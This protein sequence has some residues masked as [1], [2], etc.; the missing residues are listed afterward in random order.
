MKKAV[1]LV[2]FLVLSWLCFVFWPKSN[3]VSEKNN[4]SENEGVRNEVESNNGPSEKI[5]SGFRV[6]EL[7][8]E[9]IN[10]W[11]KVVSEDGVAISG[12]QVEAIIYKASSAFSGKN[13]NEHALEVSG[14]DGKFAFLNKRGWKISVK[15]RKERYEKFYDEQENDLSRAEERFLGGSG[16]GITTAGNPKKL[17]LRVR[18]RGGEKIKLPK[19]SKKISKD[20]SSTTIP[21]DGYEGSWEI[22]VRCLS[23]SVTPFSFE[24][25]NW[26]S[27]I[28]FEGAKVAP[29]GI[30]FG[31]PPPTEE[32]VDLVKI[33]MPKNMEGNWGRTS[34]GN[35]REFWVKTSDGKVFQLEMIVN[36]GRKH[37]FDLSGYQLITE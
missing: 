1:F 28:R 29:A 24:K 37:T 36:T 11:G 21:L 35:L 18:G 8:E 19:I 25:Y 13:N 34:P 17:Y 12:A 7:K 3:P 26:S 31:N 27:E 16:Q 33:E 14:N 9:E 32:Y 5:Q 15:V 23:E 10:F 6:R 22:K 4:S 2:L 30:S 20:G